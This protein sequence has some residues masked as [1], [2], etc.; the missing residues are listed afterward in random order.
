MNRTNYV[1]L[2]TNCIFRI[3]QM[4]DYLLLHIKLQITV[5]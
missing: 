3:N 5:E 2:A 4:I 1:H